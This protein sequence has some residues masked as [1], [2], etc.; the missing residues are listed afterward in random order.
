MNAPAPEHTGNWHQVIA[1]ALAAFVFNTTEFVPVG[2][3][4]AIGDSFDMSTAQVGLMLTLYAWVVSLTSLPIMLLTRNIE[5]RKLLVVLFGLFIASHVLSSLASGFDV[6][7]VSRIGIALSHALFWSITASLAVRVAPAGK[8]VQALGLLATGTSLAMV[9][10]IPL[11]RLLGEAMGWRTTFLAIALMAGAL[12]LWLARTLP[13]L[14]SQN[15]GSLRSLPVLFKRPA[16]VAVYG[17]TATVI[18]AQFT[19]YSYIEPFIESVAGMGGEVVTL[20]LL[21][22]GGAGIFGSLLFSRFNRQHPQRFL[23]AATSLL[24]VCLALLLPLSGDVSTLGVLSVFWG[25]AIM[26]FGLSLQREVLVLAP[27]ATDVAMALFSGIYNIG[28]GGG[29]LMGSWVGRQLGFAYIGVVGGVLAGVALVF[30]CL[31]VY[32]VARAAAQ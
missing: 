30:Y 28:I 17:L 2:L 27:D 29:A 24:A 4:S 16:L 15:S 5:R 13:L 20:I 8:Q 21:L 23:I 25:M 31:S 19:A 10:G 6:L 3:L 26:G 9:L 7:M 14:P 1:L 11:G 32:R 12:V 18:T 22:F